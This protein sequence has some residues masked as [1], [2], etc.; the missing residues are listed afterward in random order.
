MKCPVCNKEY[1]KK[2]EL[3]APSGDKCIKYIHSY[4][5]RIGFKV[6][7]GCEKF[8]KKEV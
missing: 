3:T 7:V 4:K 8:I 2:V 6:G 1:I 5:K